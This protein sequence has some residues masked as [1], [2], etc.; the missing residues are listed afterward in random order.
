LANTV[1]SWT[2]SFE[3]KVI[4]GGGT[5]TTVY[6]YANNELVAKKNP[7]TSIYYVHNDHLGSSSII[8]NSGGSLVESTRYD[9]HGR[10]LSGGTQSKFGYTGQEKDQESGFNYYDSR[11]YGSDFRRF[12]QPDSLIPNVYNPQD[13]NRYSYANNNPLKYTD[14]TGHVG[15]ILAYNSSLNEYYKKPSAKTYNNVLNTAQ[16][17]QKN[18]YQ[19][20]KDQ[21]VAKDVAKPVYNTLLGNDV[22]TLK[23]QNSTLTQ[24]SWAVVGIVGNVYLPAKIGKV[25]KAGEIVDFGKVVKAEDE[26]KN[27]IKAGEFQFSKNHPG[28]VDEFHGISIDGTPEGIFRRDVDGNRLYGHTV[29]KDGEIVYQRD[30]FEREIIN[31]HR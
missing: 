1:T 29:W 27:G 28:R 8:T 31:L 23:N 7:N 12:A 5:E 14:P 3:T 24:K 9:P 18:H 2:E 25:A 13:L 20:E 4:E 6:Y 30:Q 11:Y 26:I 22:K 10:V 21:G 19:P 16:N 17:I 15:E